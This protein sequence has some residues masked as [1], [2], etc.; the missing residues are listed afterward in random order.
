MKQFSIRLATS[1]SLGLLSAVVF[2]GCTTVPETG[3]R[4]MNFMTPGDE[5]K[6]GFS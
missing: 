4:Q 2:T 3:R 6:L 5:M 1:M